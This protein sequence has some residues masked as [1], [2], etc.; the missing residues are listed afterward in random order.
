[1]KLLALLPA[2][3]AASV[4]AA[5]PPVETRVALGPAVANVLD[6]RQVPFGF[7]EVRPGFR[8]LRGVGTWV[9][10]EGTDRERFVGAGLLYEVALGRG[11]SVTPSI[12]PGLYSE[13]GGVDLGYRLE[14]RSTLEVSRRFAGGLSVGAS[15][16]HFSNAGFGQ[17]NPGSEAVKLVVSVPL[18]R[19]WAAA[20]A[21]LSGAGP[22][23]R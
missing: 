8:F 4:A 6:R 10:A 16:G 13:S 19:S 21:A 3:V 11:W 23:P 2:L 5:S 1:M 9:A 15:F 20:R 7:V 12:G 18:A 14:F 22:R 17:H